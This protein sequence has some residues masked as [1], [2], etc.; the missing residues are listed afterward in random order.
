MEYQH[1]TGADCTVDNSGRSWGHKYYAGI[2]TEAST[3]QKHENG[4]SHK[5]NV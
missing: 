1:A 3:V 4:S 5:T 2:H